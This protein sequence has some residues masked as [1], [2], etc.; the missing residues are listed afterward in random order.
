MLEGGQAR[1]HH[2][3]VVQA[4]LRAWDE[5]DARLV[6]ARENRMCS[7]GGREG[8]K[9]EDD[10]IHAM[11]EL[12]NMDRL[13]VPSILIP[14]SKRQSIG[15]ER[16]L[17]WNEIMML[18]PGE[19]EPW[20]ILELNLIQSDE[21]QLLKITGELVNIKRVQYQSVNIKGRK[22][23]GKTKKPVHTRFESHFLK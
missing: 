15:C 16:A 10:A 1:L 4:D 19:I 6:L 12:I 2:T 9:T 21:R 13:T 3:H 14:C 5:A 20:T 22:T 8:F 18:T 7:R 17:N 11:M 23:R